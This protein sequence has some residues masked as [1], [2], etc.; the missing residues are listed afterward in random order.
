VREALPA[1]QLKQASRLLSVAELQP[2]PGLFFVP[3]HQHGACPEPA[4]FFFFS[5]A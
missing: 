1:S 4:P 5:L 2:E 3:D